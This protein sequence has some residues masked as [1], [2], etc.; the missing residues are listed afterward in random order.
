M[1]ISLMPMDIRRVG[2]DDDDLL[3]A[4]ALLLHD[5]GS[6][7]AA[8]L[9]LADRRAHAFVALE[10]DVVVGCAYGYELF[11][12]EGRWM[13]LVCGIG[14]SEEARKR[15]AGRDLLDAFA[16][17]ARERGHE[18]MFLLTDAADDVARRIHPGAGGDG[19]GDRPGAWWVFD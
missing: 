12:P 3:A 10:D 6:A 19:A 11:R 1:R 2:P 15:G 7:P 16:A 17:L 8:D 13:I 9:F 14:V 4:G 5:A 18:R